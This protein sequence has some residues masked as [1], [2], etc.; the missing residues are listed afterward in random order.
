M[1]FSLPS[2]G[3]PWMTLT[4][5]SNC[6][7]IDIL[8]FLMK[9]LKYLHSQ[10]FISFSK[11]DLEDKVHQS[12][13]S[14]NITSTEM[15][16]NHLFYFCTNAS[17]DLGN[18]KNGLVYAIFFNTRRKTIS[19]IKGIW[20]SI[21]QDLFLPF[22]FFCSCFTHTHLPSKKE[23]K[24]SRPLDETSRWDLSKFYCRF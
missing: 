3:K 14:R 9:C 19:R 12:R 24:I 7:W 2:L 22:D 16:Q 11:F 15:C 20:Q 8:K 21:D 23:G 1:C 18:L 4:A 17:T 10:I 6:C 5:A 13:N